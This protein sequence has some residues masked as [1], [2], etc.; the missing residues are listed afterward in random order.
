M[1]AQVLNFIRQI[2]SGILETPN[3]YTIHHLLANPVFGFKI[4]LPFNILEL[5]C[6]YVKNPPT[7][8]Y[9]FVLL[10]LKAQPLSLQVY[11]LLS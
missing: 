1:K 11:H 9:A 5:Q 7:T 4:K 10:I 8:L 3:P 6:L 2:T